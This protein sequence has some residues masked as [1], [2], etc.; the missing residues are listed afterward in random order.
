M[1]PLAQT[2]QQLFAHF[3]HPT[4]PLCER[5]GAEL[6]EPRSRLSRIR[7][8]G[9]FSLGPADRSFLRVSGHHNERGK[10]GTRNAVGKS[11]LPSQS[12]Q[13]TKLRKCGRG[14]QSPGIPLSRSRKR[15]TFHERNP[16]LPDQEVQ[17]GGWNTWSAKDATSSWTIAIST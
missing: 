13:S 8:R 5:A 6:G 17:G 2:V 9:C 7:S 3:S 4:L 10:R 14:K 16:I 11:S 1:T 12:Q 15:P